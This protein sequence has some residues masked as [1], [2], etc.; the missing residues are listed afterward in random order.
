M[1]SLTAIS[2]SCKKTAIVMSRLP[3]FIDPD[4][5]WLSGVNAS[6]RRLLARR[7]VLLT[8]TGTAG[9]AIIRRG[10]ERLGIA[11]ESVSDPDIGAGANAGV[12][13]D[14]LQNDRR[15]A[16]QADELLVLGVRQR[17]NWQRLL[18]ERLKSGRGGVVLVELEGLRPHTV[19]QELV[20]LGA[21]SWVPAVEIQTP[22]FAATSDASGE[23][24]NVVA[25]RRSSAA[26]VCTLEPVPAAGHW[27]FLTHTTRA[28]P[29]PW[30]GQT[31]NDYFDSLLEHREDARHSAFRTLQRI[32]QQRRLIASNR[33]IRGG[34][35]VVSFTAVPLPELPDLRCFRAH[36][37][38]W[39]FEPYG[40]CV[41]RTALVNAG[42]RPVVYGTE[43][44]W[45]QMS[46]IDQPFFQLHEP[47]NDFTGSVDA[48]AKPHLNWIR[49]QEWRCLGDLDLSKFDRQ[50]V[51]IFV[52]TVDEARVISVQTDWPVTLWPGTEQLATRG[53]SSL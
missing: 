37:M 40:I 52:P 42:V 35:S 21:E 13:A 12:T 28:C 19:Q 34:Y 44:S 14:G 48:R 17:G 43:H 2:C 24:R 36:R 1:E 47:L 39:D 31:G 9:A 11:T 20:E 50:D 41:R 49:E 27:S 46:A 53:T 32:I 38:R 45:K 4:A 23:A 26:T 29:G 18:E 30:P 51:M 6:L 10:A 3:R 15:L 33:T 16:M 25:S 8:A 22:L 5:K 7:Q